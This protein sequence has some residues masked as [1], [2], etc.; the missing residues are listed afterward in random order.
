MITLLIVLF[1]C[2]LVYVVRWFGLLHLWLLFGVV[3]LV[4]L[5]VGCVFAV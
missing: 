5:G 3:G 1:C 2:A 4:C